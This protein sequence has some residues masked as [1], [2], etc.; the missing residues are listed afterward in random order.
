MNPAGWVGQHFQAVKLWLCRINVG[1]KRSGIGP[2][3]LLSLFNLFREIFLVHC[4][5]LLARWPFADRLAN[6]ILSENATTQAFRRKAEFQTCMEKNAV[7]RRSAT[8]A[9]IALQ[10]KG[11]GSQRQ[12]ALVDE[13]ANECADCACHCFMILRFN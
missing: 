5:V 4:R 11:E 6:Q 13:P 9:G 2:A 10:R 8:L 1:V 3:L 12:K 7:G